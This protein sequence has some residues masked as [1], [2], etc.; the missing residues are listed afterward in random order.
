MQALREAGKEKAFL[1]SNDGLSPEFDHF[2]PGCNDSQS[3]DLP[4]DKNRTPSA[5]VWYGS[6]GSVSNQLRDLSTITLGRIIMIC[7]KIV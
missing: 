4:S 3:R 2:V 7:L 5:K 6:P 1:G